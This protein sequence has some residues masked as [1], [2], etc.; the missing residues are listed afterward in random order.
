MKFLINNLMILYYLK[1]IVDLFHRKITLRFN[2]FKFKKIC[3]VIIKKIYNLLT[4]KN[5][6]NNNLKILIIFKIIIDPST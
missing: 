5:K 2:K 3:W 6:L 4:I 1:K